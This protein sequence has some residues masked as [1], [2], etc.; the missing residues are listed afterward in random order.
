M[1][2]LGRLLLQ[3]RRARP[4][5]SSSR[6]TVGRHPAGLDVDAELAAC[7]LGRSRTWPL[8]ASDLEVAAQVLVDRLGLGRRLDDDQAACR[9]AGDR[10]APFSG[11]AAFLRVVRPVSGAEAGFLRPGAFLAGG[12][13]W[14]FSVVFFRAATVLILNRC[15]RRRRAGIRH[16]PSKPDGLMLYCSANSLQSLL[17]C[18]CRQSPI[19]YRFGRCQVRQRGEE[20][21]PES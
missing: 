13:D 14:P 2:A 5:V 7:F 21:S 11:A 9:P 4:C 19:I 16:A 20:A 12:E 18:R 3:A 15:R 10:F 6:L 8:L 1:S 17:W